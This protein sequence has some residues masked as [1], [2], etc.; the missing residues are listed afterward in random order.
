VELSRWVDIVSVSTSNHDYR[1]KKWIFYVHCSLNLYILFI[2]LFCCKGREFLNWNRN[3]RVE[4]SAHLCCT[5]R[6]YILHDSNRHFLPYFILKCGNSEVIDKNVNTLLQLENKF[7]VVKW[8][9]YCMRVRD[10]YIILLASADCAT[11]KIGTMEDDAWSWPN[12]ASESCSW[13]FT[14]SSLHHQH[15]TRSSR[16]AAATSRTSVCV[17]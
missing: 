6:H 14:P 17:M 7:N 12:G 10:S 2:D 4:T 15:R 5:T 13:L 16:A 1:Y 9:E 3:F 8:R 11:Y